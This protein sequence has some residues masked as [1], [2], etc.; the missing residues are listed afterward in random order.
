M[1]LSTSLSNA[2]SGLT[3]ASR[4][5]ELVSSNIANAQTASYG[6]RALV[7]VAR[8]TGASGQGVQVAGVIRQSDPVLIVARRGAEAASGNS[9][10]KAAFLTDIAALIGTA[11]NTGSLSSRVAD[12]DAALLVASASPESEAA[13][14]TVLSSATALAD[15]LN[16]ASDAVQAARVSAETS[17]AGQ[18]SDLNTALQK[19]ADLN[20]DIRQQLARNGDASALIDQRAQVIDGIASILPLREVARDDGQIALFSA[21]GAVLLDGA[22]PATFGFTAAG[23]ITPDMTLASGALSGLTLN[24][25]PLS[26]AETGLLGG[27]TLTAAFAIRDG[28]A[29]EAQASLDA[30]ARDLAERFQGIDPTLATTDPGLFTDAGNFVDAAAET[31]LAQRLTIN[32]AA[33]P[34]QGGALWRLRDGLGAATAGAVG[35]N[36]LISAMSTALN[37]A[38]DPVSGNFLP[39]ARSFATLAGDLT[40]QLATA[41]M[42]AESTGSYTS[43]R[44][45]TLV[46]EEAAAGI[47][48]DVELQNLLLIEQ[49]WA[50]N[51][52]VVQTVDAMLQ[53]LLEI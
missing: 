23:T 37:A 7:T 53:T 32:A 10:T 43:A 51:A 24:G 38:R 8:T 20:E 1:A 12:F 16:S 3:A 31:G 35:D 11:E 33:D 42:S 6:R 4:A 5:A 22:R 27:G 29:V 41:R 48:T 13:L 28:L 52:K 30:V 17:I 14:G 40:S 19:V 15:L 2:L 46:E 39:G 34:D 26:T 50:A 18:V 47:D 44:L 21:N 45:A 36:S 49:A 25:L 9:S